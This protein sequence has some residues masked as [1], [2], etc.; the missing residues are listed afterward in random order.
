MEVAI[1]YLEFQ[2]Q[3]F[4]VAFTSD[5]TQRK[6]AETELRE[7]EE[8]SRIISE[9]ISDYAFCLRIK[10]DGTVQSGWFTNSF[11]RMTGYPAEDMARLPTPS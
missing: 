10:E 11:T 2:G 7:S 4:Y 9:A 5:I 3:E 1:S 6:Q 8:C